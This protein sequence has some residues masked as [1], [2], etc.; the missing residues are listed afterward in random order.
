MIDKYKK[1]AEVFSILGNPVRL[2]IVRGLMKKS[3]YVNKIVD[4]LGVP[5]STVSQHLSLLKRAGI[6]KG[7]RKGVSICYKV[8]DPQVKKIL[9]KV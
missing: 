1:L 2:T 8:I 9:N 5:Q 3:C 6:I 7:T 4:N